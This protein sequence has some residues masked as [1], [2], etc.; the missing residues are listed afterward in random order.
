VIAC[1]PTV[2]CSVLAPL[3]D[4]SRFFT[5]APLPEA[6][7]RRADAP[8]A[9]AAAGGAIMYGLGPITLAAYLDR[10][11]VATRVSPTELTYSPT[12]RWAEPLTAAVT[13]VLLQNLS[14]LL[15]TDRILS[16][17][18]MADVKVDYQIPI[19]VLRFERDVAGRSRLTARWAIKDAHSGRYVVVKD[20]TFTRTGRAGD[21]A[22]A[23]AALSGTLG[24]LS[25]E[26]AATLRALPP[27]AR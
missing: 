9:A 15:A 18:W 20:A 5:L 23:A 10:N 1:V 4:R 19:S 3:P 13:S 11:D 8:R 24:D 21:T 17:P 14:A 6:Q 16:Y 22:A 25:S 27:P 7:A 26:I 12:D 2:G